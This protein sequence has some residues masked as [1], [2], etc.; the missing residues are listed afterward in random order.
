MAHK[1]EVQLLEKA[2]AKNKLL[3]MVGFAM[4]AG[5]LVCGVDHICD[6]IRRHGYPDDGEANLPTPKGVVL[7][8][9]DASDNTKKRIVNACT[10]YRVECIR[11]TITSEELADRVGKA[12]TAACATFDRG[13][14]DGMR[15]AVGQIPGRNRGRS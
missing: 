8:A 14:A 12:A 4:R 6:E 10:Y 1:D 7:L 5:K 9:S 11:T 3:S 15:K 13:F 2:V